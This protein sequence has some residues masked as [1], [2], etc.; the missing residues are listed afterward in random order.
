MT[1]FFESTE[2]I[3]KYFTKHSKN[4]ALQPD[5]L[6]HYRETNAPRYNLGALFG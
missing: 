2:N 5:A 3:F 4:Y 6:I 1:H